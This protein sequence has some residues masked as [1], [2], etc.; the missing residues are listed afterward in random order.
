MTITANRQRFSQRGPKSTTTKI[1]PQQLATMAEAQGVTE[2]ALK[3][4]LAASLG[5]THVE[6]EDMSGMYPATPPWSIDER[7]NEPL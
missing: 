6:I 5:A 7:D 4:K 3:E 1:L 2:A